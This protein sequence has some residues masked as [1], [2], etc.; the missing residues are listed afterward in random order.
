MAGLSSSSILAG[1]STPLG[2]PINHT[3][4][5]PESP[6]ATLGGGH[7]RAAQSPIQVKP[8]L[9]RLYFLGFA[10]IVSPKYGTKIP[11]L[12][13]FLRNPTLVCA[14]CRYLAGLPKE[15]RLSLTAADATLS[16]D[17]AILGL[18]DCKCRL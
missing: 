7:S 1:R 2:I 3:A 8:K 9:W 11:V 18:W 4:R 5:I 12:Y 14:T 13:S 6:D 10:P 16:I 15:V 17:L